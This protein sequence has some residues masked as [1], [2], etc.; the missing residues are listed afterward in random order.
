MCVKLIA[1]IDIGFGITIFVM[2]QFG[3]YERAIVTDAVSNVLDATSRR[4]AGI[5][6]SASY[7]CIA[8]KLV[9]FLIC[10]Q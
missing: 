3:Y 7:V 2:L 4:T 9:N 8:I 10:F 5:L 6:Y 1:T